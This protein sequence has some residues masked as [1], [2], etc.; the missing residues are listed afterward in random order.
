MANVPSGISHE[1]QISLMVDSSAN[2]SYQGA[3]ATFNLIFDSTQDN[4]P[5]WDQ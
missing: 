3:T 1:W 5:G 2:N 4:N